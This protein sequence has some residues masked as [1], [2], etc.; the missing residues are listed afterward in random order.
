VQPPDPA[1]VPCRV[2]SGLRS[3]LSA[4]RRGRTEQLAV[5]VNP[6]RAATRLELY[7]AFEADYPLAGYQVYAQSPDS[8]ATTLL[9]LT[10]N[11]GAVQVPPADEH[12][13]RLLIIKNGDEPVAKL[14]VLAG[15][16]P[17]LRALVTNDEQRLRVEGF[18]TG[19]QERAVDTVARRELLLARV[20]LRLQAG[21]V[22]DADALFERVKALPTLTEFQQELQAFERTVQTNDPRLRRKI[23]KLLT[24]TRQVLEKHLAEKPVSEVAALLAAAKGVAAR[25]G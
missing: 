25:G 24:D 18:I 19:L 6:P 9:G 14:P 10:D 2:H 21:R 20:R 4:R 15:W 13:L 22:P 3:P 17:S 11:R 8:A 7:S 5:A 1:I 12:P 23:D 16:E